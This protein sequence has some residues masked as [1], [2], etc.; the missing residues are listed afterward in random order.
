MPVILFAVLVVAGFTLPGI[1][2]HYCEH[3]AL[4]PIYC[5]L[6]LFFQSIC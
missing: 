2:L 4:D 5:L 3:G 6:A 1:A